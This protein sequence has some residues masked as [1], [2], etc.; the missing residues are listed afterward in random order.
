MEYEARSFS[1]LG[2]RYVTSITISTGRF[3]FV[4]H[5]T[6][7]ASNCNAAHPVPSV[8]ASTPVLLLS[9]E[10]LRLDSQVFTEV[11]S[12]ERQLMKANPSGSTYLACA[13]MLRGEGCT[14]S[15][16]TRNIDRIKPRVKMVSHLF[17]P[18]QRSHSL[19]RQRQSAL[20][21]K[22]RAVSNTDCELF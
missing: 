8:N 7:S 3:K 19:I 20:N 10:R 6:L 17:L 14:V 9:P 12:R 1:R 15:D 2:K 13:L 18:G 5:P 22:L 21:D 11:F 16:I 4:S